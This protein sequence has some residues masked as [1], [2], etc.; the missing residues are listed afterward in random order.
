MFEGKGLII[1]RGSKSSLKDKRDQQGLDCCF[2]VHKK[3][4]KKWP[5]QEPRIPP[6]IEAKKSQCDAFCMT[7]M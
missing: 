7:N 2:M 5:G 1:D 4:F 3:N 6:F